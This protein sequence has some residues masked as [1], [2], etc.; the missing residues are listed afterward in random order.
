MQ[1]L[2][3]RI[4]SALFVTVTLGASMLSHALDIRP[5]SAEAFAMA[6]NAGKPVAVHFHADWCPTCR[7]QEKIF[8]QFKS[9][10]GLDITMLVA[11]YDTEKELRKSMNIRMQSTLVVFRGKEEKARLAGETATAK[12]RDALKAGL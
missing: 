10:A 2:S 9:E 1:A 4:A 6:Q 7:Q 11:N 5:F 12:L 3:R 8:S